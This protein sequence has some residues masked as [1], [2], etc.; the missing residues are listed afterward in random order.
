MKQEVLLKI[1]SQMIS[2][3]E[4]NCRLADMAKSVNCNYSHMTEI[5]DKLVKEGIVE[6]TG[7]TITAYNKEYI[8]TDKG[9]LIQ[10]NIRDI[11]MILNNIK[12]V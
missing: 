12:V 9:K 10:S 1:A 6:L 5:K 3:F 4:D 8:L 7:D 11:I 2:K